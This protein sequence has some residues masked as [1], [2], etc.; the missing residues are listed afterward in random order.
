[1]AAYELEFMLFNDSYDA[2]RRK[3]YRGL[4]PMGTPLPLGY[5][6]HNAHYVAPFMDDP[7]V[8]RDVSAYFSNLQIVSRIVAR[9]ID[10]RLGEFLVGIDP[11]K[12]MAEFLPGRFEQL[13]GDGERVVRSLEEAMREPVQKRR[14]VGKLRL[15]RPR[16]RF[17]G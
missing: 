9:Y 2:A 14:I 8:V 15:G 5:T 3:R 1:M 4:S 11:S 10:L 17:L 7:E 6:T 13:I 16:L 12:Q